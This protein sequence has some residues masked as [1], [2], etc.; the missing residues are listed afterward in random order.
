MVSLFRRIRTR[1]PMLP[2]KYMPEDDSKQ[3]LYGLASPNGAFEKLATSALQL[4]RRSAQTKPAPDF[5]LVLF[6]PAKAKIRVFY[7]VI[8]QTIAGSG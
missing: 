2:V 4:A 3:S 6:S 1:E 5:P 7:N 8:A